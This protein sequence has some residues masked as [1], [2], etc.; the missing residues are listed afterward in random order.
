MM[1]VKFI[2]ACLGFLT[3]LVSAADSYGWT[4]SGLENNQ[5]ITNCLENKNSAQFILLNGMYYDDV[6]PEL[7]DELSNAMKSN[8]RSR[9]VSFS[10]CPTC[11][12]SAAS[13]IDKLVTH[14][15]TECAPNTWSGRLWLDM[16]SYGYWPSPWREVGYISNQKWYNEMVDACLATPDITCGM[17]AAPDKYKYIVGKSCIACYSHLF[18]VTY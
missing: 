13:Q 12:P 6:R 16:K 17:Y 15:K 18:G 10:P 14:L 2:V 3:P 11:K 4:T 8:I 9:E 1:L 5:T 7:C